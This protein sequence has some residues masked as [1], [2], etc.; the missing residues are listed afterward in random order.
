MKL[1]Y[2][3][4][5]NFLTTLK[6]L[7]AE[8]FN[9]KQKELKIRKNKTNMIKYG[10]KFCFPSRFINYLCNQSG[11]CASQISIE[12]GDSY[13]YYNLLRHAF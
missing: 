11:S 5:N 10:G 12:R 7:D 9:F 1:I 6:L 13:S 4:L 2:K 3:N 8:F